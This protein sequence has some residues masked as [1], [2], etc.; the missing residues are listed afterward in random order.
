MEGRNRTIS[1]V[2]DGNL[3][4][5]DQNHCILC[6]DELNFFALGVCGHKNVCHTCSLRMRLIMEDE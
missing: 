1:N 6:F 2:S 3:D 4:I 5:Q